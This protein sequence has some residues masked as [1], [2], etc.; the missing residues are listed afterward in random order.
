MKNDRQ[1]IIQ[2]KAKDHNFEMQLFACFFYKVSSSSPC[3]KVTGHQISHFWFICWKVIRT[4]WWFLLAMK[5]PC[6]F[7]FQPFANYEWAMNKMKS[8]I[9][10]ILDLPFKVNESYKKILE[11]ND[12]LLNDAERQMPNHSNVQAIKKWKKKSSKMK[13]YDKV[14][15]SQNRE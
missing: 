2:I 4:L 5:F 8:E 12:L 9:Q 1:E 13:N 10:W 14:L 7:Q 15:K 6:L 3:Q 11:K